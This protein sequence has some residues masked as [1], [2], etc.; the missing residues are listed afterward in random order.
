ME[1]GHGVWPLVS[2][3]LAEGVRP[4]GALPHMAIGLA[5]PWKSGTSRHDSHQRH[6]WGSL[7]I[8]CQAHPCLCL[9]PIPFSLPVPS[10]YQFARISTYSARNMYFAATIMSNQTSQWSHVMIQLV[11]GWISTLQKLHSTLHNMAGLMWLH[12][13]RIAFR[14]EIWAPLLSLQLLGSHPEKLLIHHNMS[15]AP[16][17]NNV[18]IVSRSFVSL[19]TLP[20]RIWCSSRDSG[21]LRFWAIVRVRPAFTGAVFFIFV[22]REFEG[23]DI[24]TRR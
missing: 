19:S 10:S 18:V 13:R 5:R 2:R 1:F 7:A 14:A 4:C 22:A 24:F 9:T 15:P 6:E 20:L 11:I 16:L 21:Q 23:Y 17:S 12:R 8:P 3:S